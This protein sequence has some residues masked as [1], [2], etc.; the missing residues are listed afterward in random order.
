MATLILN[1]RCK[2]ENRFSLWGQFNYKKPTPSGGT[3]QSFKSIVFTNNR[4]C[5]YKPYLCYGGNKPI[6]IRKLSVKLTIKLFLLAIYCQIKETIRNI[7]NNTKRKI[8][9]FFN[10]MFIKEEPEQI[11]WWKV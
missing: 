10:N 3:I 5:L 8:K 2:W 1:R 9:R 11:N 6:Q 7:F 4:L